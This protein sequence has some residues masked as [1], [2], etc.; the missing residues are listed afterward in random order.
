MQFKGI[1]FI[2]ELVDL[3]SHSMICI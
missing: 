3:G 2:T 1:I